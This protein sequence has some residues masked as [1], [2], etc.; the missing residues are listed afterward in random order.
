MIS[1]SSKNRGAAG[2]IVGVM[3]ED[4][5]ERDLAV[6]L[7][8]E[9]HENGPESP[10]G[11]GTQ[12]AKPQTLG[13]GD[14]DGE[15][16]GS[17]VI[18]VN[19]R[20]CARPDQRDGRVD[21]GIADREQAPFGRSSDLEC[22]KA[23]LWAVAVPPE[24]MGSEGFEQV[25]LRR[26]EQTLINQ[27]VGDRTRSI[28]SPR[29]ECG[30]Q[31]FLVDQ[32]VLQGQQADEQISVRDVA[33]IHREASDPWRPPGGTSLCLPETAGHWRSQLR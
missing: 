28:A 25:A 31:N 5:L 24:V 11:M 12:H 1:A 22:G 20:L 32:A 26:L 7:A 29:A 2:W 18:A 9:G 10:L 33:L 23:F 27:K 13:G 3:I 4:L 19:S 17:V 6:Q 21:R 8:V 15:R 14:P 16:A 30:D